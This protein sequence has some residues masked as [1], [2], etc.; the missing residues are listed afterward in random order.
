MASVGS[1]LVAPIAM[2][3]QF[4]EVPTLGA[5]H[6]SAW[7]QA[8]AASLLSRAAPKNLPDLQHIFSACFFSKPVVTSALEGRAQL[9]QRL[10]R[11]GRE[12]DQGRDG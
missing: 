3:K 5:P 8:A 7:P 11:R 6:W 9:P 12:A 10:P 2:P 1:R 4:A